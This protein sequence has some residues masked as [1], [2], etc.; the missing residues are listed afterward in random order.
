VL[1][2]AERKNGWQLAEALGEDG[3]QGMQRLLNAADWHAEAVRA[4]RLVASL[5]A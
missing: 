2:Q 5:R 4:W 3:P 1:G